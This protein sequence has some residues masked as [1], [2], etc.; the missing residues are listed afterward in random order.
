MP[1]AGGCGSG[2]SGEFSLEVGFGAGGGTEGG[3]AA[4]YAG[5]LAIVNAASAI[6][7]YQLRIGRC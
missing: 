2:A 6:P 3:P 4:A 5:P 1:P 7:T